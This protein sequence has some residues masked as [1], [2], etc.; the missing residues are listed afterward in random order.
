MN[1]IYGAIALVLSFVIAKFFSQ[2]S[3]QKH[4]VFI[5]AFVCE[6]VVIA[7]LG[8]IFYSL[9]LGFYA[10]LAS[11]KDVLVRIFGFAVFLALLV[12]FKAVNTMPESAQET[13]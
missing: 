1:I 6:F 3:T 5:S 13:E 2:K 11:T 12:G 8:G 7:L 4:V 9:K 10:D